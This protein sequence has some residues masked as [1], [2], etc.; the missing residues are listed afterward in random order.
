MENKKITLEELKK[1]LEA[2]TKASE[3]LGFEE[4][5]KD[6]LSLDGKKLTDTYAVD[7]DYIPARNMYIPQK[8]NKGEK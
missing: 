8:D 7:Y 2:L 1:T 3:A 6:S 5:L 4:F